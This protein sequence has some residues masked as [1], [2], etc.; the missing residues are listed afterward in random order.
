MADE[1]N[2]RWLEAMADRG[3]APERHEI[4]N[5]LTAISAAAALLD[6]RWDDLTLEQRRELAA[7]VR[8]RS[9]ELR[10]LFTRLEIVGP[11]VR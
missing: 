4:V 5:A 8:R 7:T 9:A 6:D 3:R 11:R 10:L 2:L 1:V